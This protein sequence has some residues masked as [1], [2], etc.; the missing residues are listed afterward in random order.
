MNTQLVGARG[1]RVPVDTLENEVDEYFHSGLRV[2]PGDTVVDVGANIGAFALAVARRCDGDVHLLCFEPAPATYE[3]LEANFRRNDVL[4]RTRHRLFRLGLGAPADSGRQLHFYAFSRFETNSTFD[5]ASKRR[6]FEIFFEDRARRL[7][8]WLGPLGV[9]GRVVQRAVGTAVWRM[10]L[11]WFL[12]RAMGLTVVRAEIS[13]LAEA[14]GS[15]GVARIDLL[16]IDVEGLELDV[17]RG[18]DPATWPRIQQVAVETNN[19]DGRQDE[20]V[21]MF[22]KNGLSRIDVQQQRAIDNGLDSVILTARRPVPAAGGAKKKAARK[23]AK[24]ASDA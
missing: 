6:E 8:V 21:E 22:E 17:L 19:R 16:K 24:E 2:A 7:T 3:A 13:T 14:L 18:I 5:L 12:R 1:S 23:D 9:L 20:I 15:A 4:M 11:W 10:F